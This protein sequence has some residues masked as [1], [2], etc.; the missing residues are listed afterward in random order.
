MMMSQNT[1]YHE[2]KFETES[3]I[4]MFSLDH[5]FVLL[6]KKYFLYK[7]SSVRQSSHIKFVSDSYRVYIIQQTLLISITLLIQGSSLLKYGE[8]ILSYKR[9]QCIY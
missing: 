2:N 3:G 5:S 7:F 1:I 6:L 9:K 4:F 8:N